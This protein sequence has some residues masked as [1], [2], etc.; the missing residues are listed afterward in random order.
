M[1]MTYFPCS[2]CSSCP[3]VFS[4]SPLPSPDLLYSTQ[5]RHCAP[6]SQRCWLVCLLEDWSSSWFREERTRFCRQRMAGGELEHPLMTTRTSPSTHL[7][8]PP[9]MKNW[10][11]ESL[12]VT[13]G[14]HFT[15]F[16]HEVVK[17]YTNRAVRFKNIFSSFQD[18]Y[19]RIDQ[20]R[21]VASLEDSQFNYGFNSQYLEKVVS[22]WRKEFNWRRQVDKMNQYPHFKTKIEGLAALL[23]H[24]W[25]R[26]ISNLFL[27]TE[28]LSRYWCSLPAC[29]AQEATWGNYSCS[30]DNGSWLARLLLWVLWVDP[31][32][33]RTIRPWWPCVWGG[34]SLHTRVW[35]LWST[36]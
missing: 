6:C 20:T 9:V 8:S 1:L 2:I 29:E 30:S 34:V 28:N 36:T 25:S 3:C 12:I 15:A 31:T 4:P 7:K 32:A 33:N 14:I 18:L 16:N 24:L 17:F 27:F 35:L 5:H 10:R 19:R 11:L 13:H 26:P 22:Y 21:P 23:T